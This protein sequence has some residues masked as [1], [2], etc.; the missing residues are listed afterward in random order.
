MI[1]E[2]D[3]VGDTAA[4]RDVE[5]N[6]LDGSD[7]ASRAFSGD[8]PSTRLWSIAAPMLA[9]SSQAKSRPCSSLFLPI[10]RL[11]PL[12]EGSLKVEAPPTATSTIPEK[13]TGKKGKGKKSRPKSTRGSGWWRP[14]ASFHSMNDSSVFGSACSSKAPL[15]CNASADYGVHKITR[16]N[17]DV[18]VIMSRDMYNWLRSYSTPPGEGL[19]A[20]FHWQLRGSETKRSGLAQETTINAS[21]A[22]PNKLGSYL[23]YTLSGHHLRSLFVSSFG[24]YTFNIWW[25][26]RVFI[27]GSS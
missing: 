3:T 27:V 26:A 5:K 12:E 16:F 18:S 10:Q 8:R 1:E 25:S 14:T 7:F 2:K 15:D 24:N 23:S 17:F 4:G 13:K 20:W 11:A 22:K 6:N 21:K 9:A 19:S